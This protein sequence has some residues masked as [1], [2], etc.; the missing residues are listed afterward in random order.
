MRRTWTSLLAALLVAPA[1]ASAQDGSEGSEP[2]VDAEFEPGD[3]L[4]VTSRDDEFSLAIRARGQVR[5][6][7]LTPERNEGAPGDVFVDGDDVD[8][9]LAIRRARVVLSGWFFGRENRYRMQLAFSPSDLEVNDDGI[10]TRTPL[11]DYYLEFR[12]LRDLSVRVGQYVLPFSRER[13]I[14]SGSLAMVDRSLL[15]DELDVDRDLGVHFFSRD[16]FGLGLFRYWAGVSAAEGRDAGLGTDLGFAYLARFEV[17]PL[18]MFDDYEQTDL[19]R[20]MQPRVA[21]GIAYVFIDDGP[22][23]QGIVG[24]L[25]ADGGRTDY[26]LA[27]A[28]AI[29]KW[30]GLT[31]EAEV[32]VRMGSRE[33]GMAVDSMGNPIPLEPP[34][35]GIGWFVQADYLFPA[36]VNLDIAARFGMLD[37]I[38]DAASTGF[39]TRRELGGAVGWYFHGHQLKLQADY[40][41]LWSDDIAVA[42]DRVRLQLSASL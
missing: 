6:T 25:P 41:H 13:V 24:A 42:E 31:V 2:G 15:N 9:S 18:G 1:L 34:R 36:D 10:P 39:P 16:L 21:F 40:F 27:T 3:G 33:P 11:L 8:L 5:G 17:L 35:D 19:S 28:D 23:N 26:H 38:G 4:V 7:L 29:F 22:G 30:A 20:R 37:P 14:S 32:T 12:H